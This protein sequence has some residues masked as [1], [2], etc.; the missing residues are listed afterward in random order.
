[1]VT[2]NNSQVQGWSFGGRPRIK[3]VFGSICVYPSSVTIQASYPACVAAART[4][5]SNTARRTP[6]RSAGVPTELQ[7]IVSSCR[8]FY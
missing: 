4:A 8:I 2:I 3:Q 1:M 7:T 6:L 5:S